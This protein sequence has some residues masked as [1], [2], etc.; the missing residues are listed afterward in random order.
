MAMF[1]L[2]LNAAN[3]QS[4]ILIGITCKILTNIDDDH[5]RVNTVDPHKYQ[6]TCG[7]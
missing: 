6:I 1:H 2:R 4:I 5:Q 7:P 3:A